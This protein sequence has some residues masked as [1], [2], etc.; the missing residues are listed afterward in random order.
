MTPLSFKLACSPPDEKGNA[1]N[2]FLR[3]RRAADPGNKLAPASMNLITKYNPLLT[4]VT[5]HLLTHG[6]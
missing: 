3:T 2:S 6:M 5:K 4:F 1:V